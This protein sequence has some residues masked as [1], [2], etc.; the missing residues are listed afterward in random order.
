MHQAPS[1]AA[2]SVYF[3]VAADVSRLQSLKDERTD[4]R[5]Y[6]M[7]LMISL[8]TELGIFQFQF[9]TNMP[10]LTGLEIRVNLCVSASL[11]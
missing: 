5:C 6:K 4:V 1:G 2:S 3:T 9:A 10:A 7:I 8:L 11:R